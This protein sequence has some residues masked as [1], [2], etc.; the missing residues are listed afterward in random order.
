[1]ARLF[2][3]SVS[4]DLLA[5]MI[6]GRAVSTLAGGTSYEDHSRIATA[7]ARHA[8]PASCYAVH[9]VIKSVFSPAARFLA[10]RRGRG[11]AC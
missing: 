5:L 9:R 2:R 7:A 1:L 4:I 8:S 10:Q 3:T 11:H 6:L